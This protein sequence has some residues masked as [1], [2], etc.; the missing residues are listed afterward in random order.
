MAQT[1]EYQTI[2]LRGKV[3]EGASIQFLNV[4]VPSGSFRGPFAVV[5]YALNGEEQKYGLRL[6]LDKEVFLDHFEDE[7]VKE[8]VLRSAA[9]QI[10]SAVYESVSR[11]NEQAAPALPDSDEFFFKNVERRDWMG[12]A[13]DA[14]AQGEHRRIF[15]CFNEQDFKWA[16]MFR[17][18]LARNLRRRARPSEFELLD[19]SQVGHTTHLLRRPDVPSIV[20]VFVSRKMANFDDGTGNDLFKFLGRVRRSGVPVLPVV[21]DQIPQYTLSLLSKFGPVNDSSLEL[22]RLDNPKKRDEVLGAVA[23]IVEETT[24]K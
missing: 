21:L 12:A 16:E 5:R 3:D 14:G 9:P 15:M 7:P 1:V 17:E 19:V 24:E 22:S 18:Y 2:D 10:V 13:R 20:I 4:R 6:D 8:S 11:R 23:R